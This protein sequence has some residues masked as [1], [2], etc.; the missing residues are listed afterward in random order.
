VFCFLNN[1]DLKQFSAYLFIVLTHK[2]VV[3]E[4]L[5]TIVNDFDDCIRNENQ[6]NDLLWPIWR[7]FTTVNNSNG[8]HVLFCLLKIS[9]VGPGISTY[10]YNDFP[11]RNPSCAFCTSTFSIIEFIWQ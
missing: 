3:I 2:I 9:R 8:L 1:T 6:T 4:P 11:I 10:R 5:H 7:S